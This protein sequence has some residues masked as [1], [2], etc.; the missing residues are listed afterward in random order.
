MQAPTY[1]ISI[2]LSIALVLAFISANYQKNQG[3][4]FFQTFL[5]GFIGMA[6]LVLGI[7]GY[8]FF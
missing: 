7:W 2:G 3:H 4:S 1:F 5:F 8:L 6:G